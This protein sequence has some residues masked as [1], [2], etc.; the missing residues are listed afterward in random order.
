MFWQA[1]DDQSNHNELL[2]FLKRIQ[3]DYSFSW[4]CTSHFI[5]ISFDSLALRPKGILLHIWINL[6]QPQIFLFADRFFHLKE[7]KNLTWRLLCVFRRYKHLPHQQ[8][9]LFPVIFYLG[10]KNVLRCVCISTAPQI[11]GKFMQIRLKINAVCSTNLNP[12]A[13]SHPPLKESW[14]SRKSTSI[15]GTFFQGIFERD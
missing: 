11:P 13:H 12:S 1:G 4:H 6:C 2:W 7:M 14:E 5:P 10:R 3:P 8:E 15:L 9:L